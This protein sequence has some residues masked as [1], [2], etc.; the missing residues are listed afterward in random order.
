M[1]AD[2]FALGIPVAEKLLRTLA[3]YAFL[4]VGLRLACKP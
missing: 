3:V 1:Y 2:L 4:L